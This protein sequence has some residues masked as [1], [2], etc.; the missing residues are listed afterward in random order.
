VRTYCKPNRGDHCLQETA[1]RAEHAPGSTRGRAA[2]L[3]GLIVE[4]DD[5][6]SVVG[7]TA[8]QAA[9][10]WCSGKVHELVVAKA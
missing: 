4:S 6:R 8:C 5:L 3:L 7:E 1:M 2:F 9:A 10:R